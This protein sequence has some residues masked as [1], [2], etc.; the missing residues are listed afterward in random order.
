MTVL[1]HFPAIVPVVEEN[2]YEYFN[3]ITANFGH[4]I[5]LVDPKTMKCLTFSEVTKRSQDILDALIRLGVQRGDFIGTLVN[6]SSDYIVFVLAVTGLGASL[7]PL[8]PSYKPY[9]IDKCVHKV[10]IQWLLTENMFVENIKKIK[11]NIRAKKMFQAFIFFSSGTTGPPKAISIDH[12]ALIA[13][14]ELLRYTSFYIFT[15]Q[16]C[17]KFGKYQMANITDRDVAY[18]V[19]PYFHAGGMLTV[20]GLLGLGVC[21]I[22]NGRYDNEGFLATLKK[23]KVSVLQFHNTPFFIFYTQVTIALL[24]PSVMKS[25]V[26]TLRSIS[27]SF[28]FLKY[29]FVGS[30]QVK[31]SLIE[32]MKY[33]L[34][35]TNI[36]Q[37]YGTTEAGAFVFMQPLDS[38]GKSESC[39]ILLPNVKCKITNISNNEECQVM[40]VGEIWLQTATMMRRY[41]E[42][43][44][45]NNSNF[46][47]NG[48]FRTGD[49]GY[50]DSD[51]FMYITGRIKEMIKVRGWQVS[52]Y[53]IEEAIQELK[54]V[55]FCAVIGVPDELS[56][57]LP[58]AYIQL[59]D[60]AELD[61]N[62]I[63][64]LVKGKFASYKQ[65][66]GGIEFISKMPLTTTNKVA[67]NKLRDMNMQKNSY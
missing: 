61:K 66:K 24:V 8:N 43:S 64:E 59:Q 38:V 48:W 49:L 40:E 33:L 44:S 39:G 18:G 52:P 15:A 63:H 62:T 9:E 41:L 14:I 36:I 11:A 25:L 20:L 50:Y 45:E 23:H 60:G 47:V 46:S 58:M 3:Q 34:P 10:A 27:Q 5:A 7:V 53:E 6:N 55:Q 1:N 22:V 29:I 56:G 67:R 51:N 57:E 35:T 54:E 30:A 31:K 4:K 13:N 32:S 26:S 28:F 12:R 17:S 65:L 2:F 42:K 19:L 16:A 21:V 37:L